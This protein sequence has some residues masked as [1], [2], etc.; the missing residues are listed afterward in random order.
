MTSTCDKV[1]DPGTTSP[2]RPS[3]PSGSAAQ[4]IAFRRLLGTLALCA[5]AATGACSSDLS[6][7]KTLAVEAGYGP[8]TVAAPDFVA[9][10]RPKGGTEF[11]PVGVSAPARP[12]RAK[13]AESQKALEAELEGARGRNESRGRAAESAGKATKPASAPAQPAQ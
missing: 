7:I 10:S 12:V 8:K 1:P 11:M 13:S 4:G 5:A 2:G 6:P 9:N 3:N